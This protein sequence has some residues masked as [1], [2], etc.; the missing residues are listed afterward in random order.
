MPPVGTRKCALDHMIH[1]QMRWYFYK[2]DCWMRSDML[3]EQARQA[4]KS[5]V[6]TQGIKASD[7]VAEGLEAKAAQTSTEI[8]RSFTGTR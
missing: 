8:P 5:H 3:S 2:D 4:G 7:E 6:R 1:E